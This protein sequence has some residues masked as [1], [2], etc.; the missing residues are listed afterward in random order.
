[1]CESA[2]AVDN[3]ESRTACESEDVRC[4]A[5]PAGVTADGSHRGLIPVLRGDLHRAALPD[6]LHA[7]TLVAVTQGA[8]VPGPNDEQSQKVGWGLIS[9]IVGGG[10]VVIAGVAVLAWRR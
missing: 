9:A 1:M 3:G 2:Q 4:R 8:V 5:C 7:R 10:L 6:L